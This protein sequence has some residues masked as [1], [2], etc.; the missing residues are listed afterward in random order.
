MFAT[1]IAETYPATVGQLSVWRDIEKM[2]PERRWEA[3]LVFVWDLPA[4]QWPENDVWAAIGEL[5]MR[6]GSL[7][8]TYV[9]DDDG[10]PRQRL[11]AGTAAEV[12]DRVRQGTADR[13]E[14]AAM[15]AAELQ[16]EIDATAELPWR[17]WLLTEDGA[18]RQLLLVVNHMAA[19]GAAMLLMREDFERLLRGETLPPARGPLEMA[20]DQEGA[21]SGRL[22]AAERHWRRTL[23]AAPRLAPDTPQGPPLGA[24]LHTGIPMPQANEAAARHEVTLA[25]LI[26][27]AYYTALREVTGAPAHL[28]YPMSANRFDDDHAAV[29]TSLNQWAPLVLDLDEPFPQLLGRT[30]WRSFAALKHGVCSPDAILAIREAHERDGGD[31]GYYY[32]P[33]LAPPG[34]P[35]DDELSDPSLERYPPARVTGPGFYVIARGLTSLDLIVR[36][37][38]PGWTSEA[39]D[40]LLTRMQEL[41]AAALGGRA[42]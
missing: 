27:G 42:L 8:T 15:E 17:A 30:H 2:P 24:T 40:R 6:H 10:M 34:F 4:G 36:V 7:R 13:A 1:P 32:N 16:R 20:L 12:G 35:S 3:N 31:P 9:I 21:G 23:A 18:P 39:L 29:V 25:S 19:D 22:R 26:L 33:I 14:R 28:F 41:L 5:G 11:A 38:R 37:H